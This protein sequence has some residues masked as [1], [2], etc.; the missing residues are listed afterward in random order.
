MFITIR[1]TRG[2]SGVSGTATPAGVRP[3][4]RFQ[5]QQLQSV[6]Q[7]LS[8][9]PLRN[10]SLTGVDRALINK[11]AGHSPTGTHVAPARLGSFRLD[12]EK[13]VLSSSDDEGEVEEAPLDNAGVGHAERGLHPQAAAS[14]R[15]KTHVYTEFC[16]VK[17]FSSLG[18]TQGCN[19]LL[20]AHTAAV[21][22]TGRRI[23]QLQ[24]PSWQQPC[25]SN[26]IHCL[27]IYSMTI[28]FVFSVCRATTTLQAQ[29]DA[30]SRPGPTPDKAGQ[31]QV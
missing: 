26:A 15:H 10:A 29:Q 19:S 12:I 18:T 23:L 24:H 13:D 30:V 2:V 28:C 4:S 21:V 6:H 9:R 31:K 3:E 1:L 5:D 17:E 25:L 22:P 20:G 11:M 8:C 7:K 14:E 27:M 16:V